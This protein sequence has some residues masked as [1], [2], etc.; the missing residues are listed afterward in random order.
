MSHQHYKVPK[1]NILTD[2]NGNPIMDNDGDITLKL[3]IKDICTINRW[4]H[5]ALVRNETIPMTGDR[6][7]HVFQTSDDETLIHSSAKKYYKYKDAVEYKNLLQHC[8]NFKDSTFII[9]AEKDS[10]FLE[11]PF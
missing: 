4:T 1:E 7:Y 8:R 10:D 2:T 9:L 5:Q 11:T 6:S 3:D